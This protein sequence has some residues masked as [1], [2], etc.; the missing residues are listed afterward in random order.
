MIGETEGR[1][2]LLLKVCQ[3]DAQSYEEIMR[4]EA[5]T[6]PTRPA[7]IAVGEIIEG[8][9]CYD[10]PQVIYSYLDTKNSKKKRKKTV[11]RLTGRARHC[12]PSMM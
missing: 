12:R 2:V 7:G 6:R 9:R 5:C 8:H 3:G 10:A 4:R 1:D 11:Y